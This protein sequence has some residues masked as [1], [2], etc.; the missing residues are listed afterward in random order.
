MGK[1]G[2]PAKRAEAE[3]ADELETEHTDQ[4][5]TAD[6]GNLEDFDAFW[7]TRK[8]RRRTT[9]IMGERVELPA[10]L[11]LQFELEARK[12]A[13]STKDKDVRKLVAILF[14]EGALS[15]WAARG[16]DLEQFGVLLAW[17]PQVIAGQD[18]TLAQ[19]ADE[20]EAMD[21]GQDGEG[22]D[23]S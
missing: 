16:M 9:T 15:R 14:G 21:D 22:A 11:P 19:V 23:P 6:E 2:N 18:V 1:S 4:V 12:R 8:R 3:L 20:L 5:E 17:A 13:K 10:S 7:S